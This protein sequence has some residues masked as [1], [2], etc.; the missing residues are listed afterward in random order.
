MKDLKEGVFRLDEEDMEVIRRDFSAYYADEDDC[1]AE[2]K[3]VYTESGYLI[4]THTAVASYCAEKYKKE[5]GDF[6]PMIIVSTASPFKFAPAVCSSLGIG[7][8]NGFEAVDLLSEYTGL[9]VPS[10]ISG[11]R[12]EKELFSKVISPSS[13]GDAV[14][15]FA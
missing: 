11:I 4:D 10:P 15:D 12:N 6:T 8:A 3:R 2:I 14:G 5:T 7:K 1:M 13:L 9:E